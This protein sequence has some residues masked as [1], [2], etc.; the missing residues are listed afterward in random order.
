MAA[1]DKS[2][3]RVPQGHNKARRANRWIF[4]GSTALSLGIM[5]SLADF[6]DLAMQLT[7][8]GFVAAVLGLHLLGRSGSTDASRART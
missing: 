8:G 2:E 3:S 5:S 1:A 7:L 6:G 4:G